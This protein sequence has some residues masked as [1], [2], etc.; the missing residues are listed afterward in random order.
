MVAE[1]IGQIGILSKVEM[2]HFPALFIALQTEGLGRERNPKRYDHATRILEPF[3]T[4]AKLQIEAAGGFLIKVVGVFD[5]VSS[6]FGSRKR[7]LNVNFLQDLGSHIQLALQALALNETRQDFCPCKWEQTEAGRAKGQ[8][9]KQVWFSGSHSDIGGGWEDAHDS[10]DITLAW[11][12][13]N[14]AHVLGFDFDYI[15]T[16]PNPTAPWGQQPPHNPRQGIFSFS[17]S[18]PRL[19]PTTNGFPTFESIHLSVTQQLALTPAIASVLGD[20]SGFVTPLEGFEIEFKDSWAFSAN[21]PQREPPQTLAAL[22]EAGAG[23]SGGGLLH[24]AL[25]SSEAMARRLLK[26]RLKHYH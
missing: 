21:A 4:V 2:E 20:D 3:R 10:A 24:R 23:D 7:E 14:T 9:L 5:T 16:I 25:D 11:M 18:R 13:S 8:V 15:K 1:I 26:L 17:F 12:I 19:P 6:P 22:V